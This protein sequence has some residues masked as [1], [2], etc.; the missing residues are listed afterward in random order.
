MVQPDDAIFIDRRAEPVLVEDHGIGRQHNHRLRPRDRQPNQAIEACSKQLVRIVDIDFG[1]QRAGSGLQ[2]TGVPR[3]HAVKDPTWH[4]RHHDLRGVAVLEAKHGVLRHVDLDPQ[5]I[6][7]GDRKHGGAARG[8]RRH[9]ITGIDLPCGNHAVER[10]DHSLE[11]GELFEP[12]DIGALRLHIGLGNTDR[13]LGVRHIGIARRQAEA[14]I[15]R[16]LLRRVALDGELRIAPVRH[17]GQVPVRLRLLQ[18]RACLGQR[19]LG[20]CELCARLCELLIEIGGRNDRQQ[21]S[22]MHA[23]ADIDFALG[24]IAGRPCKER[25]AV[26]GLK[27]CRQIER[28]GRIDR[29]HR[30]RADVRHRAVIRRARSAETRR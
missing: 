1:E 9:E 20:L 11:T 3:D 25:R 30:H 6:D 13:G 12:R 29:N 4:F 21:I 19:R 18:R 10:R 5:H 23:A 14:R 8:I 27:C 2:D 24:N 26:E 7:P 17:V 28:S 22:G 16:V 15:V